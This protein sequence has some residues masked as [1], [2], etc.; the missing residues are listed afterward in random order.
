MP[1]YW[2]VGAT[3]S[4]QNMSD[5]F[6]QKGIWF[7]DREDVQERIDRIQKGDRLAIKS[8][9]GQGATQVLIKALGIVTDIRSFAATPFKFFYVDWLDIRDENRRVPFHGFGATLH[10]V[11]EDSEIARLIFH[12]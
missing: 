3:V 6:L 4:G 7:A 1:N 2:V 5:D 12:L 9:L 10:P 11:L 8:L